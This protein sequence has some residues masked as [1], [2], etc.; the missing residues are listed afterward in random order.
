MEIICKSFSNFFITE[1]QPRLNLDF[2][3]KNTYYAY[4]NNLVSTINSKFA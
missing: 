2:N 4:M 3:M 1:I